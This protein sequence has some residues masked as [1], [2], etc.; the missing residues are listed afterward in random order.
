MKVLFLK[1][2]PKIG[3]KND[4][5]EVSDGYARNF[6][7]PKNLAEPATKDTALRVARMKDET[8]QMKKINEDLLFKNLKALTET[9]IVLE[10]KANEKGHL[11]AA[12]RKEEIL[13]KLKENGLV[14]PLEYIEF[15]KPIKEIG[16]YAIPVRIGGKHQTFTLRIEVMQ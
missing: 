6:L 7:F 12:I 3:R 15:E 11:F 9:S 16:E 10:G 8:E 2:V 14:I 5:K 1:D 13:A 4:V